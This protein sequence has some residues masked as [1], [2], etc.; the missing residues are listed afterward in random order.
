MNLRDYLTLHLDIYVYIYLPVG[1]RLITKMT[2]IARIATLHSCDC[3]KPG[4]R[5]PLSLPSV[6]ELYGLS[7]LSLLLLCFVEKSTISQEETRIH[8]KHEITIYYILL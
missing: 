6:L 2:S 5:L 8:Y 7:E 4:S 3:I 1:R